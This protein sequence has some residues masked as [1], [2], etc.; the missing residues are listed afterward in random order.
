MKSILS[1]LFAFAII[2]TMLPVQSFAAK[3]KTVEF[4]GNLI[5][6]NVRQ[7]SIYKYT[8]YNY[9]YE[10]ECGK[11]YRIPDN[12]VLDCKEI[13]EKFP[14]LYRLMIIDCELEN[15]DSL[16]DIKN[17]AYFSVTY[18]DDDDLNNINDISY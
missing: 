2:L 15:E 8:D 18:P 1:I 3:A 16:A 17:L 5:P 6:A 13:A 4:Y 9:K 7:L 11:Q 10:D 14:N 12:A